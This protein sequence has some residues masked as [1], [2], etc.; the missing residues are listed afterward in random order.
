[1]YFSSVNGETNL[2]VFL[3]VFI[4]KSFSICRMQLNI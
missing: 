2:K 3:N 4:T 1:M